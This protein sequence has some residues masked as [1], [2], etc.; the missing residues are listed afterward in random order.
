MREE[1]Y[2]RYVEQ[3]LKL[4]ATSAT[5]T[6]SASGGTFWRRRA[7]TSPDEAMAQAEQILGSQDIDNKH[8]N[9][10]DR[11]ED[12][13]SDEQSGRQYPQL[14]EIAKVEGDTECK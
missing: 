4:S 2:E 12:N 13:K 11:N 8:Q 7:F 6:A 3:H 9:T 14:Y 10:K 1:A 5:K